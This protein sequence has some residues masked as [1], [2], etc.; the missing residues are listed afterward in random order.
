MS[1]PGNKR[2][3]FSTPSLVFIVYFGFSVVSKAQ[4]LYALSR[5]CNAAAAIYYYSEEISP[6]LAYGVFLIGF[7]K[8][9]SHTKI[10]NF[11]KPEMNY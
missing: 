10:Q 2:A 11:Q 6:P 5:L 8:C 4:Y 1:K 7:L 9:K 3:L